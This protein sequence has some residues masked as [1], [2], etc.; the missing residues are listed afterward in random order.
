MCTWLVV[1]TMKTAD[2][3]RNNMELIKI[4]KFSEN[5]D[6]ATIVEWLKQEGDEVTE[7]D[8]LLNVITDKADFEIPAETSGTL[9][10]IVASEK[11]SVPINYIVGLVGAG[12][13][14]LPDYERMNEVARREFSA[15]AA[16]GAPTGA[17]AS[18]LEGAP[19]APPRPRPAGG[20][21]RVPATPAAKRLAR[22]HKIELAEVRDFASA[23][24]PVT[25]EMVE[26]FLAAKE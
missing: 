3:S 2:T 10:K 8:P 1:A 14:E 19:L 15:A 17:D 16:S 25:Q 21:K 22:K 9:L 11:S 7:G 6:E 24:G 26:G 5:M 13:E 18:G 20:G 23:N 12:D 4:P